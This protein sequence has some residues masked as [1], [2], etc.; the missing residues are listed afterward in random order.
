MF[1]WGVKQ[2]RIGKIIMDRFVKMC[3]VVLQIVIN[4]GT[5]SNHHFDPYPNKEATETRALY[6]GLNEKIKRI[7]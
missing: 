7:K 1:Y 5:L 2:L 3:N 6:S 4:L